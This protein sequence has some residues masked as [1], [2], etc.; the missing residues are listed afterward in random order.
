MVPVVK[1]I[2]DRRGSTTVLSL[3]VIATL[4]LVLYMSFEVWKVVSIKKSLHSATY[5][6]VKFISLNGLRWGVHGDWAEQVRPIVEA[7]LL[8]NPFLDSFVPLQHRNPQITVPYR[9]PQLNTLTYCEK[10]DFTLRVE[11]WYGIAIPPHW[12]ESGESPARSL[13]LHLTNTIQGKLEC[14]P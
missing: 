7:E 3:F 9:N 1:W 10:G 5:Q 6:A 14:Y 2:R 4:V 13:R 12:Q 8:N 11:L